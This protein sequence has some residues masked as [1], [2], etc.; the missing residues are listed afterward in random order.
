MLYQLLKLVHVLSIV[1]WIGG[2]F[3][4]HFCLRPGGG[5]ARCPAGPTCPDA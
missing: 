1:I 5:Q 2:M 3:F 4:A